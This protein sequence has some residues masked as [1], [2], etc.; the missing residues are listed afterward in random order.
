MAH[1]TV[2]TLPKSPNYCCYTT[3]WKSKK[4]KCNITAGYYHR[5]LHQLHRNGPGLS[6]ALNLLIWSIMWQRMYEAKIHDMISMTCK[7]AWCKLVLTLTRTSSMLVWPSEIM[8]ACWWWTLWSHALTW[9]FIY[10]IHQNILENCQ[11]NLMHVMF[12]L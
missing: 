8:C 10:M 1:V 6:C 2:W 11:C 3:L 5:K 12:I 9:M 7:N 4:T